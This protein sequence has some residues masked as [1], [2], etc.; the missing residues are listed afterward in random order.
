MTETQGKPRLA[1]VA[2]R[3]SARGPKL[4][5]RSGADTGLDTNAPAALLL[6]TPAL[7]D[8]HEEWDGNGDVASSEKEFNTGFNGGSAYD[9]WS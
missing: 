2:V 3:G 4:R 8:S 5:P 7:A 6:D 1:T 9:E